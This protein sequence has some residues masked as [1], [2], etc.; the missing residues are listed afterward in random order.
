MNLP[1]TKTSDRVTTGPRG[2]RHA[3]CANNRS[4]SSAMISQASSAS[5]TSNA[6]GAASAI[7]LVLKNSANNSAQKHR[8]E[9]VSCRA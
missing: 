8:G 5:D 6:S 2:R 9:F 7:S 3:D 1:L 4:L